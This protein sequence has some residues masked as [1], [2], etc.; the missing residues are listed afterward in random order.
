MPWPDALARFLGPDSLARL[1]GQTPWP[2]SVARAATRTLERMTFTKETP[3]AS[4]HESG[5]GQVPAV[6]AN[7]VEFPPPYQ[8]VL[9]R[10]CRALPPWAPWGVRIKPRSLAHVLGA[11]RSDRCGGSRDASAAGRHAGNGRRDFWECHP[12]PKPKAI[13]EPEYA[14]RIARPLRQSA[15]RFR[16]GP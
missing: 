13:S 4:G 5:V 10:H 2:D 1:L 6:P 3:P 11:W 7:Q 16:C 15:P 9:M 14:G 8:R 12:S